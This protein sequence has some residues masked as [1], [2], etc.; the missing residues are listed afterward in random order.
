MGTVLRNIRPITGRPRMLHARIEG[1]VFTEVSDREIAPKPG[2]PAID[3]AG[4][5]AFSGFV[6]AHTH[7]A[8]VILRGLADDVPL[9]VWLNEYIWP[10]ERSLKPEDVYWGTLLAIAEAIRGGTT[11][12]ADM[13]FHTDQVGRAVEESGIRAVLSYGL[14]AD[15]LDDKGRSELAAAT[16]AVRRWNGVD[17]GRIK[18]AISPHAVYTCGKDVWR[19]AIEEAERLDV[20][21]HTHLS[22]SQQEV[23]GWRRRTGLSPVEYLDSLGVFRVRTL[24]AHCVHVDEKEMEILAERGVSVAHCPKSNAKLGNGIAPVNRM[25]ELGINVAIGTDGAASN[26]RL[27]MLEELR[28]ALFLQRAR[29]GDPMRPSAA[30]ALA[31]ATDAGREALSLPSGEMK[32]GE[33]AD[34]VLIDAEGL[35]ATPQHDPTATIVYAAGSA[36]VTDMIVD[37]RPLMRNGE[38]LT[39]D[40]EKA[41]SE[42]NRLL[43]R[44]KG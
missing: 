42:V 34:L 22:E 44:L 20:P 7:L 36:E 40:E 33:R 13:Y 39:I 17:D 28:C 37:G 2:E 19:R 31:M 41:K 29:E 1:K 24:A 15:S 35:S 16:D 5:L 10:I 14:I 27:D 6:N 18:G 11:G 23:E 3:G 12:V 25:R 21:I 43:R 30:D 9:N 4:K 32:V 8:M 38:L 26:N